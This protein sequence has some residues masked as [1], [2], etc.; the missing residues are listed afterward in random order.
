MDLVV[1]AETERLVR[2]LANVTGETMSEAVAKAVTERLAREKAVRDEADRLETILAEF[3]KDLDTRPLT[4]EE[5][6][7]AGGDDMDR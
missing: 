2:E 7:W 4:P 1:E 6:L 3:R 5:I